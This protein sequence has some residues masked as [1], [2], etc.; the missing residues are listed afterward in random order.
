MPLFVCRTYRQQVK[1]ALKR[2]NTFVVNDA[3]MYWS[4]KN[5][6]PVLTPGSTCN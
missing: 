5:V 6:V 1:V 4:K 2:V 3:V